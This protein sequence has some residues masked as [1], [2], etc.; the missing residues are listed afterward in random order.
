MYAP[1]KATRIVW[2]TGECD[3]LQQPCTD[4]PIA[5]AEAAAARTQNRSNGW[6]AASS[7]AVIG[8]A[9]ALV[10][11]SLWAAAAFS[12]PTTTRQERAMS[13]NIGMTGASSGFGAV[14]A[15][16]LDSGAIVATER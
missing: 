4:I 12:S 16:A 7:R 9:V 5:F 15:R 3:F 8:S 6:P 11:G 10:A 14:T 1:D 13:K 2:H